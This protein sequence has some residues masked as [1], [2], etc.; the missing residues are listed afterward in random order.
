MSAPC[1]VGTGPT[2]NIDTYNL[3]KYFLKA[4]S[5]AANVS[6]LGDTMVVIEMGRFRTRCGSGVCKVSNGECYPS[7]LGIRRDW[8]TTLYS[9]NTVGQ[10]GPKC[11]DI[12][13][14][15]LPR[16]VSCADLFYFPSTSGGR[17]LQNGL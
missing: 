16:I 13:S 7:G 12:C 14:M 3:R 1:L 6:F 11:F 10:Q 17:I 8:S 15:H 4:V 2:Y 9:L 5:P